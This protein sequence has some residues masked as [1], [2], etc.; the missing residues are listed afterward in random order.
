[1]CLLIF[2]F[3][4]LLSLSYCLYSLSVCLSVSLSV[5]VCVWHVVLP[6]LANKHKHFINNK[7]TP[8]WALTVGR[9]SWA[10]RPLQRVLRR[11]TSIQTSTWPHWA[12]RWRGR[13][14]DVTSRAPACDD[15]TCLCVLAAGRLHHASDR[16]TG[17][18]CKTTK[19][20]SEVKSFNLQAYHGS[21]KRKA[22]QE[23]LDTST[24]I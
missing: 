5:S 18:I 19:Y 24:L 2:H 17:F 1:M 20:A 10:S 7:L 16:D 14:H 3:F 4:F 22:R 8:R 9:G 12:Q 23:K 21:L 15:V 6:W 11:S 13:H